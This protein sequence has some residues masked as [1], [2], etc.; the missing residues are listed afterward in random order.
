MQLSYL[1]LKNIRS[2]TN[3]KID[4]PSGSVLLCGDIG[5]GKSTILLAIEFALFGLKRGDYSGS[6]L[7]R[8]GENSGSVELKFLIGKGSQ[9]K[10]IVV[11]RELKRSQ[12][13]V[14]QDS[15]YVMIENHKTEG[16]PVE[17]KS[18]ILNLLGYPDSL[19]SKSKDMIYRYTVYTPQEDMKNIIFADVEERLDTLRRVFNIDKYKRIRDNLAIVARNV[20]EKIKEYEGM[21]Y[22]LPE[23]SK[24]YKVII[25]DANDIAHEVKSIIPRLRD[26]TD[27]IESSK[28]DL[29]ISNEKLN[30]HNDIKKTIE[31][32][33]SEIN[34]LDEQ[35]KS[36]SVEVEALDKQIIIVDKKIK[37]LDVG[38][39]DENYVNSFEKEVENFSNI[40]SEKINANSIIK[41][42]L[43]DLKESADMLSEETKSKRA[44]E[45][46]IIEKKQE[47]KNA[48]VVI[49]QKDEISKNMEK[50]EKIMQR[51][52]NEIAEL[53]VKH[54]SAEKTIS[55]IAEL[56]DCP[57]CH[58]KVTDKYKKEIISEQKNVMKKVIAEKNE[59]QSGLEGYE[60]RLSRSKENYNNILEKER[61]LD[62]MNAELVNLES[63][64]KDFEAKKSQLEDVQKRIEHFKTQLIEESEIKNLN[65]E[66]SAK[67]KQLKE[68]NDKLSKSR[69]KKLLEDSLLEKNMLKKEKN[70][71]LRYQTDKISKLKESLKLH[72]KEFENTKD[73][74]EV[75]GKLNKEIDTLREEEKKL[76]N[77]KSSLISKREMLIKS[78]DM[79]EKEI[80]SMRDK[81]EKMNYLLEYK[82]W[83]LDYFSNMT[84]I[85]EKNVMM[86]VFNEFN[87]LFREW[88]S[89]LIED[90]MLSVRLNEEFTPIIEQNGYEIDV[91]DLSGGEKTSCALAYRLALN[92]VINDCIDTINTKDIIIL[93]EPTDG[94]SSE[95]LDR[96][97]DVLDIININQVIIVSHEP[98]IESFVDN[99]IKINKSEHISSV[100]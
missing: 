30:K 9:Q 83:L 89:V 48:E 2:Y 24:Q 4:F 84:I 18:M 100:I 1:K 34:S 85:M 32:I 43:K 63:N 79:L 92:K 49:K 17:L 37:E 33:E 80:I 86:R 60:E 68:L 59:R 21:I 20:R 42:K 58:Q 54:A 8:N 93:D 31:I 78:K 47:I 19:L 39:I 81:K 53:G 25:K 64:S 96:L 75:I 15:G 77:E 3:E 51:L 13:S 50:I 72:K 28:K 11:Y 82:N 46:A 6:S 74:V 36:L 71:K 98:K 40:I 35:S 27:K 70:E 41:E 90:E 67:K 99:I 29:E 10:N 69:E 95:Q 23:K 76:S 44:L 12:T 91:K 52:G 45:K 94:F 22:S 66:L 57:T 55:D 56:S 38:A 61:E 16:T 14:K 5:S 62:R 26:I 73:V 87:D 65:S 88:F 97:R 7:L